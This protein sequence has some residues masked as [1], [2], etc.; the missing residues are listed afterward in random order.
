MYRPLT[1][2]EK[3]TMDA[4]KTKNNQSTSVRVT[5]AEARTLHENWK[6]AYLLISY[7]VTSLGKPLV[8]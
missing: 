2:V 5:H 4:L 6:I 7:Y 3:T 1:D 8:L